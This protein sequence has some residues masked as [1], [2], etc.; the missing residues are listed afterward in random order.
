MEL[1][2]KLGPY[3]TAAQ[4]Q[5][6]P[7][8]REGG[9][10]KIDRLKMVHHFDRHHI[11]SSIRYWDKAA[12]E[13]GGCNTAGVLMHKMKPETYPFE[14]LVEHVV[15]GQWSSAQ[16]EA[17]MRQTAEL[18]LDRTKSI[19]GGVPVR[20]WI[21][22][23]PGSGGKDSAWATVRN[24]KGFPV[25]IDRASKDKVVR[26]EPMSAQV[27]IGNVGVVVGEWTDE[28]LKELE[29]FPVGKMKDRVDASTGAFNKLNAPGG[30]AG[31]WGSKRMG[32]PRVR[33]AHR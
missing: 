16:R 21:E 20:I 33:M 5:Q 13:G 2:R 30:T 29:L 25:F 19:V 12:T 10:F 6:R 7:S 24:L 32:K 4:L 15:V 17:I 26:A 18:D 28:Y 22:Q 27:E 9:M 31:A 1:K 3:G 8:P 23:E 11:L 14:Y